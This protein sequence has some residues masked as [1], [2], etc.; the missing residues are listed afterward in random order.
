[1]EAGPLQLRGRLVDV[2]AAPRALIQDIA[3]SRTHGPDDPVTLHSAYNL[4]VD[5]R[6]LGEHEQACPSPR[7]SFPADAASSMTTT[8]TPCAPGGL[9]RKSSGPSGETL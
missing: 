9:G 1:V 2:T 8:S 7:T 5:L 3:D 6:A 4:A